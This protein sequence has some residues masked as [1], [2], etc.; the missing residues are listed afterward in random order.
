MFLLL[1]TSKLQ[2]DQLL[3]DQITDKPV[4]LLQLAG[5]IPTSR[6]TAMIEY[7]LH[8]IAVKYCQDRISKY[9]KDS[10]LYLLELDQWKSSNLSIQNKLI[11][12][13]LFIVAADVVAP[14]TS[15]HQRKCA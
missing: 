10:T 8:S 13:D 2:P 7:I 3:Y 11:N 15:Q 14:Y 9:H 1:K 4:R 12:E 6:F 5:H